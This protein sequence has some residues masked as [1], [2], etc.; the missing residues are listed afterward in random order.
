MSV[1]FDD[2][3][4]DTLSCPACGWPLRMFTRGKQG[5]CARKRGCDN[6]YWWEKIE[7]KCEI[8]WKHYLPKHLRD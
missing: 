7:G 8:V 3:E 5:L 2:D 4:P 6:R 1:A